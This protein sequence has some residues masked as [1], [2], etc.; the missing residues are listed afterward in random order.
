MGMLPDDMSQHIA[1]QVTSR[2]DAIVTGE[3]GKEYF[4]EPCTEAM[5]MRQFLQKL[6]TSSG[7]CATIDFPEYEVMQCR[8]PLLAVAKWQLVQCFS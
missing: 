8:R 6:Q 1:Q 7:Q 2:A 5:T 3:D 4:A